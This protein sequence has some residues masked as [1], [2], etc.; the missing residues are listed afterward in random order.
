MSA[1]D[2]VTPTVLVT[3]DSVPVEVCFTLSYVLGSGH[4]TQFIVLATN[5]G[6]IVEFLVNST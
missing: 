2:T 1:N 4:R 6:M 3:E 5:D